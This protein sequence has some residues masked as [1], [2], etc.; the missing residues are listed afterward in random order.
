MREYFYWHT[1]GSSKQ[2]FDLGPPL[3]QA[4]HA[5]RCISWIRFR[6]DPDQVNAQAI[7][8]AETPDATKPVVDPPATGPAFADSTQGDL[9]VYQDQNAR[10]THS[11]PRHLLKNTEDPFE[12][13]KVDVPRLV[14]LN[15]KS[16][17]P[18]RLQSNAASSRS[19]VYKFRVLGTAAAQAHATATLLSQTKE[20]LPVL[21]RDRN[22]AST[23][24]FF[25][26]VARKQPKMRLRSEIR[27][28][29]RHEAYKCD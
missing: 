15:L 12:L 29:E 3:L 4:H 19:A 27:P 18:S 24:T 25:R 22:L 8:E 9:T 2:V 16:V 7:G 17:S 14:H 1:G 23:Y 20:G 28:K 21:L 10:P 26:R 5:W 6:G 13:Q 11:R